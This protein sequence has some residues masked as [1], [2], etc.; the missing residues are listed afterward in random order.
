MVTL[1]TSSE[2]WVGLVG[3]ELGFG[4]EAGADGNVS[5]QHDIGSTRQNGCRAKALCEGSF[6]QS[7]I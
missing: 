3:A 2:S 5:R 4:G 1:V 6:R 7:F